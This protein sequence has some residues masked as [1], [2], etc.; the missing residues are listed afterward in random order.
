MRRSDVVPMR[1]M[2]I[3]EYE[4]QGGTLNLKSTNYPAHGRHGDLPL[5]GKIPMAE[6]GIEPGTSWS[7][8]WPL[9][10]E[11]G[12]SEGSTCVEL[13]RLHFSAAF[14]SLPK[15]LQVLFALCDLLLEL[16]GVHFC[17]LLAVP[18]LAECLLGV[19]LYRVWFCCYVLD[20]LPTFLLSSRCLELWCV[21]AMNSLLPHWTC[22]E[23]DHFDCVGLFVH[24][25]LLI[26][27]NKNRRMHTN[28]TK[29]PLYYYYI[30][31]ICFSPQTAIFNEYDRYI[32]T[33]KST[34]WVY[35][36]GTS[37]D[38]FHWPCCWNLSVVLAEDGPLRAETCRGDI[39]LIKW[40]L[41]MYVCISRSWLR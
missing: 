39:V 15:T 31:P 12:H 5:Q 40:C 9:D 25:T 21:V 13:C 2:V 34:K 27:S 30:T 28:I 38:S 18:V 6:L 14:V 37:A 17:I 7:V 8:L 35:Q 20:L 11:A 24:F 29:T 26:I 4:V 10:H 3:Y 33:A 41:I 1:W 32:S 16:L 23:W 22:G 36:I 19:F